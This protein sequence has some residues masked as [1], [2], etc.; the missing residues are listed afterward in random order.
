MRVFAFL[1]IVSL[2]ISSAF[3]PSAFAVKI[4]EIVSPGGIKAWFVEEKS[5]PIV[6]MEVV[7]KG[8]ASTV[9]TEK[10]GLAH[11]V[12][13]TM[14]EGAADLDS[15]AF[16][17]KLSDL[18]ISLSFNAAKDTFGGSLKTLSANKDEAFRL[19]SL[20]ITAPRFDDEPVERIRN[21][22]LVGLNRKLAN[23][24]SLAGRA[25]F[26]AAFG[27][28]SYANPTMGTIATMKTLTPVDLR[29]FKEKQIARDNMVISV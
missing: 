25:W 26:K 20:A 12:A 6:S 21:Q 27:E 14:D 24:N 3:V 11:L 15:K 2:T 17:K 28:H 19:F 23:P 13:A 10:A 18:A 1:W 29:Q 4:Q 16:Q 8:G 22:I 5:I 9:S 7:W